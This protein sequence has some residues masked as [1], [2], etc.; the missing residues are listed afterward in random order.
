MTQVT[1]QIETDID[2]AGLGRVIVVG[3][4]V[5]IPL[6]FL[7]SL[8]L[9]LPGVGWPLAGE[10]AVWPA[11]VGGP[12][13]GGFLALMK[14]MA[15]QNPTASVASLPVAERPPVPETAAA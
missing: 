8:L 12:F 7:V 11:L 14:M 10:I 15:A 1:P 9:S 2:D 3:S 6:I 13:V 4:A 5:G